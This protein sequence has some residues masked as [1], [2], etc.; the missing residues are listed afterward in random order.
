MLDNLGAEIK[1]GHDQERIMDDRRR[2]PLRRFEER[3]KRRLVDLPPHF[4]SPMYVRV[5]HETEYKE[6][7]VSSRHKEE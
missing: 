1:I 5:C 3:Y 2:S 7:I 6:H 4:E